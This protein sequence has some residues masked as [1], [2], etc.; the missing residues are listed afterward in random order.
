MSETAGEFQRDQSYS[1]SFL[2]R[3]SRKKIFADGEA[4]VVSVIRRSMSSSTSAAYLRSSATAAAIAL[5]AIKFSAPSVA[6]LA[7]IPSISSSALSTAID[8]LLLQAFER[9]YS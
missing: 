1:V 5:G 2:S 4:N 3:V 6:N 7:R 9:N 8:L